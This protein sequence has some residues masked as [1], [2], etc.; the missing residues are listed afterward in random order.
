MQIISGRIGMPYATCRVGLS[1]KLIRLSI[2]YS[3]RVFLGC[4]RQQGV[5]SVRGKGN[6]RDLK[7]KTF[8]IKN[9]STLQFCIEPGTG[10]S[11]NIVFFRRSFNIFRTLASFGSPR[12]QFVY[13]MAGQTPALQQNWRS[14]EESQHIK[15]NTIFNEP[16]S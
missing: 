7:A 9:I 10:C 14:S 11:L 4:C 8:L 6:E 3:N 13:T 1:L 5:G 12:C 2:M 16:C 15:E